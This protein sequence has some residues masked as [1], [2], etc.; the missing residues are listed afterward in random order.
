MQKLSHAAAGSYTVKWIFT[1]PDL[2]QILK[3]L[4]IEVGKEITVISNSFGQIL[5]RSEAGAF[6]IEA[7]AALG[8]TV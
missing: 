3:D 6:V 7:D 1:E 5:L 4:C 8:V 2:K